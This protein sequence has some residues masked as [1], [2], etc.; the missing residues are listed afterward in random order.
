[1]LQDGKILKTSK[2]MFEENT[3]IRLT[4][5]LLRNNSAKLYLGI[6]LFDVPSDIQ[7]IPRG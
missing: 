3:V 1:M 6:M 4:P 2:T 5:E 7:G